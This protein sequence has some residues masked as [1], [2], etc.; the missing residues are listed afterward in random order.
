VIFDILGEHIATYVTDLYTQYQ[1]AILL[2]HNL[3]H[4]QTVVKRTQEIAANY[5]FNDED[6]FTLLAAAWFH[7]TGHLF[8]EAE[9][10]EARSVSVMRDYLETKGIKIKIID[11]IEGCILATKVP[12]SPKSLLEEII[13]DADIYNLGIDDF[14]R[15]DKLLKRETELRNNTLLN[16]WEWD[17]KTLDLLENHKYFTLYCQDTLEKGRQKNI[18]ILHTVLGKINHI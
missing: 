3:Y 2:Y 10:H 11:L 17:K 13:C 8:A 15:T 12:Q 4:T 1:T 6:K 9:Y 14:F 16:D 5:S 7:D 18:E